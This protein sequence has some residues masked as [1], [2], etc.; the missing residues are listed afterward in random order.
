VIGRGRSNDRP[1]GPRRP[2][3]STPS[4]GKSATETA[5]ALGIHPNTVNLRRTRIQQSGGHDA[6]DPEG[7]SGS[8]SPA[9]YATVMRHEAVRLTRPASET[10]SHSI[11]GPDLTAGSLGHDE[12][13]AS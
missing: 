8:P 3:G 5:K 10:S 2:T 6:T 11:C 13:V 12:A 4:T 9:T 7:F 1:Q